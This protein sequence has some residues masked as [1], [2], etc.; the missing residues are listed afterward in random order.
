MGDF[1]KNWLIPLIFFQLYLSLSVFLF[2]FGPWPWDV[3]NPGELFGYL[4]LAQ[5]SIAVGYFLAW[6]YVKVK[7]L[8]Y[9]YSGDKSDQKIESYIPFIKKS[10]LISLVFL[11]PTTLSRTGTIFP[12]ILDGLAKTGETYVS[13]YERLQVGNPYVFVEYLRM[14]AS[15]YLTAVFP[16]VVTY[17]SRL[18]VKFRFLGCLAIIYN[19][20]IY[21]SIGTNKGI[22]DAVMTLPWMLYLAGISGLSKHKFKI[23]KIFLAFIP[24]LML[25]FQFFGNSQL[26]RQGGAGENGVIDVGVKN[27]VFADSGNFISQVL[28]D[29]Q[30][31]VF[32]SICRYMG[33]G[34]Y[35][36]S[37]TMFID[38]PSTLGFGNSMFLAR[39]ANLLMNTDFFTEQSLPGRL[40]TQSGFGMYRL[41]HSI[42]P[43]IASDFGFL[44]ALF[45]IGLFSFVF[46]V[47]WGSS[48][49]TKSP[50]W[51]TMV[52]ISLI[53]F[54]YIP[55][56]NQVF[57]SG[58][59]CF[60]FFLTIAAIYSV[61]SKNRSA[62]TRLLQGR[63]A[64]IGRN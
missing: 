55:A 43:W 61:S 42:Y 54:Y 36:L 13:N 57:Q 20:A 4:L 25:F 50:L 64:G 21:V 45:I 3:A 8:N 52:Y 16:L 1:Q 37:E 62:K 19:I 28:P 29:S 9:N 23:R 27:I 38:S 24:L 56:N 32:E 53:I 48:I 51:I 11:I 47:S 7:L 15:L 58:E 17:W 31:I 35:A 22:A 33:S 14:A 5:L 41:W 26:Q 30:R 10:I 6:R 2:F 18:S 40:E 49:I 12:N 60:S 39:Q 46:S 34:Y 59:G 44:G 63:G